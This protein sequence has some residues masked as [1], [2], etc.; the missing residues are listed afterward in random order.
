MPRKKSETIGLNVRMKEPL[1]RKIETASKSNG[2]SM[3]SELVRRVE[4]TF[5]K[6]EA[7]AAVYGGDKLEALFRVLGGAA[8]LVEART[9]KLL[10]EDWDTMAAVR[11]AWDTLIPRLM[12]VPPVP[13]EIE[14]AM[15]APQPVEAP[16]MPAMPYPDGLLGGAE[17][18]PKPWAAY[19]AK[20]KKY[21]QEL[22]VW[23]ETII[24]AGQ[25]TAIVTERFNAI[26][27][28]GAEAS[29]ELLPP[30]EN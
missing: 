14:D 3:N 12:P 11:K 30:R 24:K 20:M 10:T 29:A 7:G 19:E 13:P 23:K 16:S 9:E 18:D 25:K 27:R 6:E 15:N 28:L 2:V 8:N 22:E 1:R 4:E 26:D 5:A 17:I 21:R